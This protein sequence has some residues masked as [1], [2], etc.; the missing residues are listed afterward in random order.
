MGKLDTFVAAADKHLQEYGCSTGRSVALASGRKADVAGSRTYFSWKG[1]VI[2]SQHLLVQSVEKATVDDVKR[3][4]DDGFAYG[5]KVNWVPLLRGMQF[6]YMVIQCVAT[7]EAQPELIRYVEQQPPK[8]WALFEL[9][10]V[11][12]LATSQLHYYRTTG[13]W[14]AAFF[15][16]MR[17]MVETCLAPALAGS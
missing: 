6:G 3:L 10:V 13:V 14:G 8:H 5:K 4:F 2:Q 11:A 12:D 7:Y 15:S 17:K 16:D 1:F 9:P